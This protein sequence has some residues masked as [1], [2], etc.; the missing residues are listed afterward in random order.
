MKKISVIIPVFN[1]QDTIKRCLDSVTAQTYPNLEIIVIN[2]GSTDNTEQII[3]N[4]KE[5]DKR[6]CLIS[7]PN[8]GVSHARNIGLDNAS[9]DY[10][11]FVDSD[12][13]ID[14]NMYTELMSVLNE[15][16]AHIAHCSYTNVNIDG[17]LNPVGDTGKTVVQSHNE[18]LEY[19]I[20]G[21]M[22]AGGNC[23]KVYDAKFFED[24]RFDEEISFNEDVWLCF[25][26]FDKTTTSVYLDKAY[27]YYVANN[28]SA[29]HTVSSIKLHEQ[30]TEIA[31]RI[32][33]ACQGKPYSV[34][35]KNKL[36][37]TLLDLYRTYLLE[38]VKTTE[39][40]RLKNEVKQYK[41]YY[42]S[43]NLKVTFFLAMHFP[44]ICTFTYRIYD[45]LRVKK[46]DPVQ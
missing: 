34:Y 24:T 10:I 29:T 27:Y 25:Q 23:N 2:D 3:K 45:K 13:Y 5:T 15:N 31:R 11:T 7:I 17:S 8:G 33:N 44:H 40:K 19:L 9:G 16:N 30:V 26:L 39:K 46:L 4:L 37:Y 21:K 12:D 43:K 14:G 42:R 36:A 38:G 18:A 35:A 6:I 28:N 1:G 32:D 20:Q 41:T 22:F